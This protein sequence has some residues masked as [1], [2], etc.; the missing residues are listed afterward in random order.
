MSS[1]KQESAAEKR[2]KKSPDPF[3]ICQV[4]TDQQLSVPDAAESLLVAKFPDPAGKRVLIAGRD[5]RGTAYA[6]LEI[7]EA[8]RLSPPAS[9]V[10]DT[11]QECRESPHLAVRSVTKQLFNQELERPWYE[12][13]AY[14]HWY[15]GMLVK[16]RFNNFSMTFGHNANYMIPPYASMVEVAEFPDVRIKGMS[17]AGRQQCL[18]RFRRIT[19]IAQEHGIDF[20][21]GLWTQLPV[22]KVREGLDFGDS[23][24]INLPDG[25]ARAEYCARGLQKLLEV[26]PAI[27]GVQLR[28]NLESGIPHAQQEQ[29]YQTLFEG[30]AACGR[31]V[32]L[33]LR[34]KSL[35]QKTIN[36]AR[37]A[38]LDV[39][40]S[41]KFWCEHMGLPYSPTWQDVAYSASRYGFGRMLHHN[42]NYSVTYRLWNVGTSRLLLWGDP[43]YAARFAESCTL[44]GGQGFEVF[45]PLNYQGY[46]NAPGVW[47]ILAEESLEHYEWEQERYWPFYISFGRF[48][49][50]PNSSREIWS[51][52]FAERF[53]KDGPQIEK[54]LRSASQVLPLITA[55]TQ[56]SANG[57]RFW[58]EMMTCMHLDAY[59]AIQPSDYSQFYAIAPYSSRQQWRSEDWA[60]KHSAFVEDAIQGNLNSKWTPIQVSE[61]LNQLAREI[62]SAVNALS[63]KSA[64][65]TVDTRE[66]K[67]T[68]VDLKTLA[69]L[70]RYHADKKLAATHLEFF[71][72][73]ND[74][75][76]LKF[77]WKH[78]LASQ[79]HWQKIVEITD[80]HYNDDL[81][82]G[83][84]K[85]YNSDFASR[86][87]EHVG[88]WKDR[89]AKV[90]IDVDFVAQLLERNAVT[91]RALTADEARKVKRYPGEKPETCTT[92]IRHDRIKSALP[93]QDLTFQVQV[94]SDKP[95]EVVS[96]YYRPLDQTRSWKRITMTKTG[97]EGMYQAKIN[98]REID[99]G[100]DFQYYIEARHSA[101]GT[102]WPRWQ[103]E[104]PYVVVPVIYP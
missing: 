72:L 26:C 61:F 84:S 37:A 74:K 66:L 23:P 68:V 88:H 21:L 60:S 103:D 104:T 47:R 43:G 94:A 93:G 17:D 58:P 48:G 90:Q 45:A 15:F 79:K 69:L 78:I 10:Y 102:F 100:F 95:L 14:W 89:L 20:T 8:I 64:D 24:V 36:L 86:L 76:R 80:G 91:D 33:D 19:E 56:F 41:T 29:Y 98:S 57:W 31:P 5:P 2:I 42:R 54:A 65:S 40:V 30:I 71:R 92:T 52:E 25:A 38:G 39:N 44:G 96:V 63:A 46:G 81:V 75:T 13:E 99:P 4:L 34:Y 32:K 97:E 85:K 70:A 55:S 83:H 62:E 16:N 35:S 82:L 1:K 101:G 27:K 50:N 18:Q 22:V 7:S 11:I 12:S 59:R 53:G 49:Y 3:F 28:M 87:Q 73:T 51:R 77:A 6:L 9:P 67:A